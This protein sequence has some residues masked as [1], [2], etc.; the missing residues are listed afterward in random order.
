LRLGYLAIAIVVFAIEMLIALYVRDAIIR[1]Y[2]GDVLAVVLVYATLRAITPLDVIQ[3]L[4][5]TLAIALAIE[6]AQA[7]NLLTALGL[8]G[9]AIARTVLGG[10][11]DWA[12][13][14]AYAAG[15]I[16]VL[17]IER[18]RELRERVGR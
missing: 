7:L 2:V 1:P 9:N 3:A 18:A 14:L 10:V 4:A 6:V 12:D 16:L 15:A 11:F 17:A 5:A 13:L 8:S